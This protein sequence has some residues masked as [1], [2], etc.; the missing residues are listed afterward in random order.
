MK[1]AEKAR[2]LIE[3][4]SFDERPSEYPALAQKGVKQY[5]FIENVMYQGKSKTNEGG[6][7]ST[8]ELSSDQHGV[9]TDHMDQGFDTGLKNLKRKAPPKPKE[10]DSPEMVQFKKAKTSHM[11]GLRKLEKND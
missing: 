2:Q 4:G 8:A 1:S 10:P 6:T 5:L 11:I 7:S 9:V 3:A